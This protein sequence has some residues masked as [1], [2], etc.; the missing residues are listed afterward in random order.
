MTDRTDYSA[1][2]D[3]E[4]PLGAFRTTHHRRNCIMCD[5]P[6]TQEEENP[7]VVPG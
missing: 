6:L 4:L 5:G 7:W 3:F 1:G 2:R